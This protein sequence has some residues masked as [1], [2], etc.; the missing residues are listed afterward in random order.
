LIAGAVALGLVFGRT[1]LDND[2]KLVTYEHTQAYYRQF[3][4][5]AGGETCDQINELSFDH[6]ELRPH[7]ARFVR[8]AAELAAGHIITDPAFTT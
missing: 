7:C 3:I 1:A 8:L 6:P 5:T 2:Q 4:A